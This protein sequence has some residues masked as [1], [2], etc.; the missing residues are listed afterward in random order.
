MGLALA[1]AGLAC[2]HGGTERRTEPVAFLI[3]GVVVDAKTREPAVGVLVRVPAADAGAITDRAGRFELRGHGRPARYVMTVS[4]IGYE[5]RRQ[6]I[7]IRATGPVD[8]GRIVMRPAVIQIDDLIAQTC[9]RHERA[10]A[11]TAPG[12]NVRTETDS[13]GTFWLVCRRPEP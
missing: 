5:P 10:P 11:D 13:T 9:I 4:R 2:A 7:R 12:A 8:V 1:I 3:R 6:R